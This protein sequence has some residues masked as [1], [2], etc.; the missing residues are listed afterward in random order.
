LKA[1]GGCTDYTLGTDPTTE[2]IIID[3]AMQEITTKENLTKD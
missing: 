1:D 2:K 3:A